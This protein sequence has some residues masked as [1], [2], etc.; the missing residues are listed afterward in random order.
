MTRE[1]FLAIVNRHEED[2][3]FDPIYGHDHPRPLTWHKDAVG[4]RGALLEFIAELM[5]PQI[6][7]L[8][9]SWIASALEQL[10][11]PLRTP[12]LPPLRARKAKKQ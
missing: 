8:G 2:H 6:K 7:P 10:D 12:R 11:P 4:D 3:K 5:Q 1:Q 9:K